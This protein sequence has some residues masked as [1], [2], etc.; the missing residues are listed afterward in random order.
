VFVIVGSTLRHPDTS[1]AATAPLFNV[2]GVSLDLT[3]GSWSAA[4]ATSAVRATGGPPARTDVEQ[5]FAH[6]VPGGVYSVFWGTLGP[7]SENPSCPGVERTLPLRSSDPEQQ[8]DA[9]SFV[10]GAD[11]TATFRGHADGDLL[12]ASQA[13]FTLV[14]HFDGLTWGSLP[15]HGEHATQGPDCRSSFGEDAMRQLLILQKW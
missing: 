13:Y 6:L 7:D 5:H 10:A 11:G 4:T 15:N 1:T 9:S 14:Y 3:W 2:A 8:P 12:A